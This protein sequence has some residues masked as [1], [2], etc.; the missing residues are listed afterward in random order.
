MPQRGKGCQGG[1]PLSKDKGTLRSGTVGHRSPPRQKP[2]LE[3]P[4]GSLQIQGKL[5]GL[6]LTAGH[7]HTVL[8]ATGGGCNIFCQQ[9]GHHASLNPLYLNRYS[10]CRQI[11]LGKAS[12]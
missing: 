8:G 5:L 9:E 10:L 4:V 2:Y 1:S 11:K 3:I 7:H 12:L 6:P